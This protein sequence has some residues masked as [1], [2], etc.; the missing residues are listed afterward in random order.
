MF[1]CIGKSIYN[2]NI[3]LNLKV[4]E[5]C[6]YCSPDFL[7][8]DNAPIFLLDLPEAYLPCETPN[9]ECFAKIVNGWVQSTIFAKSFILNLLL[10]SEYVSDYLGVFSIIMNWGCHFESSK[11]LSNVMSVLFKYLE[12][13]VSP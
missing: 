12:Q 11:N 6:R 2:V 8:N 3:K 13:K 7:W 4:Q 9:M 5:I 1:N 10:G